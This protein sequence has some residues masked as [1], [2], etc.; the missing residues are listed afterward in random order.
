MS[1]TG[2]PDSSVAAEVRQ[3]ESALEAAGVVDGV[4]LDAIIDRFLARATPANGARIIAHAW[5]DPAFLARLLADGNAAI[6]ELGLHAGGLQP[7]VFRV[8]ANTEKVHNVLVCT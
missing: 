7:Q 4:E 5:A 6:A 3:L 2:H 8:V 1:G